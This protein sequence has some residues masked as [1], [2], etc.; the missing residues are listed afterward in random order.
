LQK[1]FK[2][3]PKLKIFSTTLNLLNAIKN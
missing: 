1:Q 2:S 3:F